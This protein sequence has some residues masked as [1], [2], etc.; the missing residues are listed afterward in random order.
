VKLLLGPGGVNVKSSDLSGPTPLYA[1]VLDDEGIV[2]LLVE[3]E[4]VNHYSP[5]AVA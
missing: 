3:N 2:K 4:N 1:A 5:I